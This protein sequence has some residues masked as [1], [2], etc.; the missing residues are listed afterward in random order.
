MK[1]D[2]LN[3]N[4][5]M[6]NITKTNVKSTSSNNSFDS[7]FAKATYSNGVKNDAKEL[8]QVSQKTSRY[9][10]NYKENYAVKNNNVREGDSTKP[11]PKEVKDALKESGMSN[12][13]VDEINSL[14]DLKDKVEPDKLLTILLSLM[15]GNSFSLD[16]SN[17]KDRI[18]AIID[19]DPSKYANITDETAFKNKL[20]DGLFAAING[21]DSEI[22]SSDKANASNNTDIKSLISDDILSKVQSELSAAL[23]E[24]KTNKEVTSNLTSMATNF[25]GK[26]AEILIKAVSDGDASDNSSLLNSSDSKGEDGFL[27]NLLSDNNDKISRVTNFMSQF[28][29]MKVDNNAVSDLQKIVINKNTIGTDMIKAL[30]YMQTN[31]MKDLIV[32]INP[33]E[34][35]EV[36]IK[37][38]ME[39]GAMKASIN[40]ANKEAYNLLNSNLADI[41][42]KLQNTDIKIQDISLS[43][44][45]EDTTFFKDGSDQNRSGREQNGK[46]A[47]A[48]GAIGEEDIV[49]DNQIEADSNVN[50]LA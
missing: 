13:E 12:E 21:K 46:K 40:A 36:V 1:I 33:K 3:F 25:N 31:D 34:L 39:S 37:I 14:E 43:L 2:I 20:I 28:N 16:L 9:D 17:I 50:I 15:N 8:A 35:G 26:S 11:V 30:K 10:N 42:S 7:L 6:N 47:Q 45:N 41:T 27:K 22:Q 48:I 49:I 32:K 23:K 44:Y 19:A 4:N 5:S 29:N 24:L 18:K 38:T